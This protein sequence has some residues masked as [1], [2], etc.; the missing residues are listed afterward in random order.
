M[1]NKEAC[2]AAAGGDIDDGHGGKTNHR[3]A[4]FPAEKKWVRIYEHRLQLPFGFAEDRKYFGVQVEGI[5]YYV[6]A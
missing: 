5:L 6:I 2:F 3:T 4:D 1:Q